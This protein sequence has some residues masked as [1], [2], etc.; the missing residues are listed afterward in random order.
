MDSSSIMRKACR[1]TVIL[2]GLVGPTA[3]KK[4]AR[5]MNNLGLLKAKVKALGKDKSLW[6]KARPTLVAKQQKEQQQREAEAQAEEEKIAAQLAK[7]Q[8]LC[9]SANKAADVYDD[10]ELDKISYKYRLFNEICLNQE[11]RN[12][13]R[14]ETSGPLKPG[15]DFYWWLHN[16]KVTLQ[17]PIAD[18]ITFD[19]TDIRHLHNDEHGNIVCDRPRYLHQEAR[20]KFMLNIIRRFA[21]D[22][23]PMGLTTKLADLEYRFVAILKRKCGSAKSMVSNSIEVLTPGA[24]QATLGDGLD[25]RSGKYVIQKYIKSKGTKAGIFRVFWR[26]TAVGAGASGNVAGWYITRKD[27]EYDCYAEDDDNHD[28]SGR[29]ASE[30][31]NPS[32]GRAR[33]ASPSRRFRE[34]QSS[35]TIAE[36]M[37][38]VHEKNEKFMRDMCEKPDLSSSDRANMMRVSLNASRMYGHTHFCSI[39]DEGGQ[40]I[41]PASMEN[42][43]LMK[44]SRRA[45][46]VV[47]VYIERLVS[48]IQTTVQMQHALI[49]HLSNIVCD[50]VRDDDGRWWFVQMK[51]FQLSPQSIAR[52]RAWYDH[53]FNGIPRPKSMSANERRAKLD[54]ERGHKCKCCGLN[55]QEGQT[56]HI[57]VSGES[58]ARGGS[59]SPQKSKKGGKTKKSNK[60]GGTE[61]GEDINMRS[62]PVFGYELT[63]KMA[64]RLSEIYRDAG[65]PLT[66]FSRAVLSEESNQLETRT[67]AD[68]LRELEDIE[69]KRS[70][71]GELSC[72]FFCFQIMGEYSKTVALS[73]KM[74]VSLQ[75]YPRVDPELL[76]PKTDIIERNLTI[77]RRN[78]ETAKA[79]NEKKSLEEKRQEEDELYEPPNN[80]AKTSK[81]QAVALKKAVDPF[82]VP[83]PS[84]G[85]INTN[86]HQ[87]RHIPC[88]VSVRDIEGGFGFEKWGP[89]HF[90]MG[91]SHWR[92]FL[93]VHY[94][95]DITIPEDHPMAGNMSCISYSMGQGVY[96]LP[97]KFELQHGVSADKGRVVNI[98]QCRMHHMCGTVEDVQSLFREKF[99]DMFVYASPQEE[100]M[101]EVNQLHPNLEC[102]FKVNIDQIRWMNHNGCHEG[103]EKVDMLVPVVFDSFGEGILRISVAVV[104]DDELPWQLT[105][106]ASFLKERDVFWPSPEYTDSKSLPRPWLGML[107]AASQHHHL[108]ALKSGAA[109]TQELESDEGE[110]ANDKDYKKREDEEDQNDQ[111]QDKEQD[112]E[113]DDASNASAAAS[114][115]AKSARTS[116]ASNT[117]A[118]H[119]NIADTDDDDDDEAVIIGMEADLAKAMGLMRNVFKNM[120]KEGIREEEE[121]LV[122]EKEMEQKE[123]ALRATL[124]RQSFRTTIAKLGRDSSRRFSR[125]Q[126]DISA[127]KE[128]MNMATEDNESSADEDTCAS[129]EEDAFDEPALLPS[130]SKDKDGSKNRKDSMVEMERALSAKS[131]LALTLE[132]EENHDSDMS[133][134][135]DEDY[136]YDDELKTYSVIQAIFLSIRKHETSERKAGRRLGEGFVILRLAVEQLLQQEYLPDRVTFLD[137][138]SLLNEC[139]IWA[140]TQR[141]I[142]RVA[143]LADSKEKDDSRSKMVIQP[144]VKSTV[145]SK[146]NREWLLSSEALL[147]DY[148]NMYP[149]T[150][151]DILYN[152]DEV[153]HEDKKK[154]DGRLSGLL[155]K[156]RKMLHQRQ[157]EI[158]AGKQAYTI[159]MGSSERRKMR[160]FI[161]GLAIFEII[162]QGENTVD[163]AEIRAYLNRERDELK[164]LV[165]FYNEG[166]SPL[167]V[168]QRDFHLFLNEKM[169]V[170]RSILAIHLLNDSNIFGELFDMYDERGTAMMS[171]LGFLKACE[172][173]HRNITN[174]RKRSAFT[175]RDPA[176]EE[177]IIMATESNA[178]ARNGGDVDR[179]RSTFS[180]GLSTAD[181]KD[182]SNLAERR[183]SSR[184]ADLGNNED[185]DT[186]PPRVF[187]HC[188][189]HGAEEF[190]LSDLMCIKCEEEAHGFFTKNVALGNDAEDAKKQNQRNDKQ[191]ARTQRRSTF[192]LA[193]K[194]GGGGGGGHSS[195][196]RRK[197]AFD[198]H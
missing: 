62:V 164:K 173:A 20:D 133:D 179:K 31:N 190:F 192:N 80:Q 121:R 19:D 165:A 38:L 92:L 135:S 154:V 43:A 45:L 70:S 28:E 161:Y 104:H 18:T 27:G 33:S 36:K 1:D 59:K 125:G 105:N 131:R 116:K 149:D 95:A 162:A 196:M 151:V 142:L 181:N 24:L 160:R 115:K 66:K 101:A 153:I 198:G 129:E 88:S 127:L 103:H 193:K 50:F 118:S 4:E 78:G 132:S 176:L 174:H 166:M 152:E 99:I 89:K 25:N 60:S 61:F 7:E 144:E 159:F 137:L 111:D 167:P 150:D 170:P 169:S 158:I 12:D 47:R 74:V 51:G 124:I 85:F 83:Q 17:I 86:A 87:R 188:D 197:S 56:V 16:S 110:D 79:L 68:K 84:G 32:G 186:E 194:K 195:P 46:E 113:A 26:A 184:M 37:Q 100:F 168:I 8:A 82:F 106:C 69:L 48:W 163:V 107:L 172:E 76:M 178:R 97:F 49:M 182:L 6:K 2:E 171:K 145:H 42:L 55:F 23:R 177:F 35:E 65:F 81:E 22:S 185:D 77:K 3:K 141:A 134:E 136:D 10:G 112:K 138:K 123:G 14:D 108:T 57:E 189:E 41:E 64:C 13:Y 155:D 191:F 58:G 11:R 72:C 146:L 67:V 120:V 147:W 40:E 143:K 39:T 63:R 148:S 44:V 15:F 156:S 91:T 183:R 73:Q 93:M 5:K 54:S 9:E 119:S 52:C 21:V 75:T 71:G 180:L 117:G 130:F 98:Q 187:L 30:T 139:I 90:K 29:D 96:H 53:K 34:K 140:K 114:S 157:N 175:T 109:H 122:K 94:I 102:G 128:K 126:V